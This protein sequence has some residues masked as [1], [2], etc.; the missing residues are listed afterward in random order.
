MSARPDSNNDFFLARDVFERFGEAYI[1]GHED[2]MA[3]ARKNENY[4]LGGGRQWDP[5]V[6]RELEGEGRPCYEVNQVMSSVNAAIGYQ[7]ANRVDPSFAPRGGAADEAGATL[8]SK[9]VRQILDNACWHDKETDVC[10]DGFIQQRGYIDVRMSYEQSDLG[11]PALRV[12]DPLDVVPDPD[13]KEQ[14]V[15]TWADAHEARWLTEA[16][17]EMDYG[18]DAA[19]EV[20]E[21]ANYYAGGNDAFGIEFGLQRGGFGEK[22]PDFYA[23]SR[24][25][26]GNSGAWRRYRIIERQTNEY[27]NSLVA[28]WP[29]GDIR[30][31][32]G[33]PREKIGWLI[34]HG[35]PVFKQRVRRVRWVTAAPEVVMHND[36][37]PYDHITLVPFFPYF[38]RGRTVGMVD[39]QTSVQDMLNKF[40]SQYGHTVNGS[41]NGGW[42]GEAGVLK[43]MTDEQFTAR[44][45]E[46]GLV[47]LRE[48]GAKEF[49]KIQPNQVPT[50]LDRMVEYAHQNSRVVSGIDETLSTIPH[51]DLSGKAIQSLQYAAQQKLA[52]P[53][54]NLAK[55]RRGVVLR[56][57][58]CVQKYMGAERIMRIAEEAPSGKKKWV[59]NPLNVRM[60]DGTVYNDL[61]AGQYDFV[62]NDV[63][64]SVTFDN[65]DFD[66]IMAM[67]EAGIRISDARVIRA[68]NLTDKYEIAEEMADQEADKTDPVTEAEV[69][70]KLA[71][72]RQIAQ[73]GVAKAIEAQFSAIKT[74]REIVLT[75][76]TARIADALLR[77][78]G[79]KDADAAPIVPEA[80]A[81]SQ[82][83]PGAVGPENSHPMFP[84]HPDTGLETGMTSTT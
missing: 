60:D 41:A 51:H 11:L 26:L 42:Q 68:S 20:K 39:N 45:S 62:L 61:T 52:L 84:P 10:L 46:T 18:A 23:L 69:A 27:V 35:I 1:R 67:R 37:S 5:A 76:D 7:M 70:L 77:S 58:E 12:P 28:R 71:Q 54:G 4:Y 40:L 75:P 14:D 59:A 55:T 49:T 72:A 47:L 66:Q 79:F 33:L 32:E 65:T 6:R 21:R 13:A 82:M 9:V 22:Y 31:V 3:Q 15:D 44:G 57:L 24:G 34:D 29:T 16:Q 53:L 80:P 43:N 30:V 63:A 2:Y 56:V 38:R 64:T 8:M 36:L 74:A 17:I 48:P 73:A 50:G 25:W 81:G 78:G 83:P 19:K